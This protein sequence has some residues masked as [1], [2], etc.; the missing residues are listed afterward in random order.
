[1]RRIL[2][3][4]GLAISVSSYVALTI[5]SN[6][7]AGESALSR[8]EAATRSGMQPFWMLIY[9]GIAMLIASWFVPGS[10]Q[11]QHS[12][13]PNGASGRSSKLSD[14][15]ERPYKELTPEERTRVI[16]HVRDQ[17]RVGNLRPR[18]EPDSAEESPE[19]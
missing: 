14:L 15:S 4:G 9:L 1:M 3:W 13:T 18:K 17:A 2:R 11:A 8:G 10:A 7:S 6:T 12:S 5:W 19:D 16:Q